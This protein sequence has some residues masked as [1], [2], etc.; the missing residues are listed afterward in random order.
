MSSF[1]VCA[2]AALFSQVAVLT[3]VLA[4]VVIAVI[5]LIILIALWRKVSPQTETHLLPNTF[6]L[7]VM[8]LLNDETVKLAKTTIIDWSLA[9]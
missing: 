5:F 3:A 9:S 7:I 6:V 8:L 2:S 4:L 1:S